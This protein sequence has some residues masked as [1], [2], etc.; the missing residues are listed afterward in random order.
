MIFELYKQPPG[1]DT[2][3]DRKNLQDLL[4]SRS[5]CP[6]LTFNACNSFLPLPTKISF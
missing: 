2:K 6:D 1:A 5:Y 4:S 3:P